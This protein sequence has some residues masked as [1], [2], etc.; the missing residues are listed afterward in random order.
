V[1]ERKG[2]HL[3]VELPIAC[4]LDQAAMVER[5]ELLRRIGAAGLLGSDRSGSTLALRFRAAEGMHSSLARFIEL[6]RDCCPFL[7]F[8]LDERDDGLLLSIEAPPDAGPVLD[9]IALATAAG[10]G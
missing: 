8:T 10:Q 3:P 1:S 5:A 7:A 6:E 9:A 4:S 2:E